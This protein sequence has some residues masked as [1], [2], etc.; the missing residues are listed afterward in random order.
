LQD[1]FTGDE[2]PSM[3]RIDDF[4]PVKTRR[5]RRRGASYEKAPP[6][7]LF[8]RGFYA[9]LGLWCAGLF[10]HLIAALLGLLILIALGVVGA[11]S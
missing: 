4:Q 9:G 3:E 11:A 8:R 5:S 7:E 1:F 10:I 2:P 6:G